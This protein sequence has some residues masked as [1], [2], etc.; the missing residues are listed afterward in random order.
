MTRRDVLLL[1]LIF[2]IGAAFHFGQK[3]RRGDYPVKV[4]LDGLEFLRGPVRTFSESREAPLE[5]GGQVEIDAARGEVEIQTWD[6]PQVRVEV[7]KQLHAESEKEGAKAAEA[8]HLVLNPVPGGVQARVTPGTGTDRPA[9][10]KTDF[11]VTVPRKV[12]LTVSTS[13]GGVTVHGIEGDAVI[14][15]SEGDVDAGEISGS[16][17][18]TNR[19][20][21][22]TAASVG[23][24]LRIVNERDDVTVEKAGGAVD[25]EAPGGTV[26]VSD[27]AGDV[28]I[29]ADRGE[30]RVEKAG[31]NVDVGA[32][33]ATVTLEKIQGAVT[34]S[35]EEDPLDASDVEGA[36]TVQADRTSVSLTDVRG[37]IRVT[38]SHTDVTLV[39]P[40]SDVTVE[41]TLQP[42]DLTVPPDRGFRVEAISE[43][44]EIVSDLPA[45]HL[46]AEP[47]S[48]FAGTLGDGRLRYRLTTSHSTIR[49]G[50][51]AGAADR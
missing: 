51:S 15:N 22:V 23:G 25:I 41:T 26:S 7:L 34:A 47:P 39:R 28:K 20:G 35:V 50:K 49:I 11:T 8:L 13:H 3:I 31:G 33:H 38:A 17:E 43:G 36:A 45:L 6:R 18:I 14:R 21:A 42:I 1:V 2:L 9:G 37:R 40:G 4:Q 10:L 32:R 24:P 12:R 5:P 48:R 46:P 16:C 19:R 27:A 29:R 44:G 30:V